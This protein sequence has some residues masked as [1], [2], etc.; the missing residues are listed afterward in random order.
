MS[1][2]GIREGIVYNIPHIPTTVAM[3]WF[4]WAVIAVVSIVIARKPKLVPGSIQLV[5]EMLFDYVC[6]LA[7]EIVGPKAK[8]YY[9]L[10]LGL[11]FFILLGNLIGL[12]P[13]LVSPT[14][15]MNLT[16]GLAIMV[17]IYFNVMGIKEHGMGYF[18]QFL[19]P[20]MP[21]ALFP[22]KLLLIVIEFISFFL[23]PFSLGLRLFCNIFSKELFLTILA[24]LIYS[25]FI[26]HQ[27]L[28][29]LAP[30]FL[31]PFILLLG[32]IVAFI[33]ALVFMMLSMSYIAGAIQA[34]EGH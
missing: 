11:F 15:D 19:G 17:F 32:L 31:R 18:K 27:Y 3:A 33:Q 24:T 20:S 7:D 22:I 4:T 23:R 13:C 8:S 5:L 34:Q 30:L 29:G 6:G 9:P 12:I 10:F 16:F 14:S 1:A 25:F 2:A 26:S 21:P 28:L